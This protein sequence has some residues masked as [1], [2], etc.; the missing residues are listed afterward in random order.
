LYGC[1]TVARIVLRRI[2]GRGNWKIK[3]II[4]FQKVRYSSS[5]IVSVIK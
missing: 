4:L 2:E 3:Q 1:E 5:A